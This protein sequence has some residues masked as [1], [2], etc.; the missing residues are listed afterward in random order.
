MLVSLWPSPGLRVLVPGAAR[1][2]ALNACVE[3]VAPR[4]ELLVA[5]VRIC[6]LISVLKSVRAAALQA[7]LPQQPCAVS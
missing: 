4:V 3:S 2:A 7:M 5:S 1:G 6:G